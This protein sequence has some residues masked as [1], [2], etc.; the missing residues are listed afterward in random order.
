MTCRICGNPNETTATCC[1]T[2]DTTGKWVSRDTFES[3]MYKV[4][5]NHGVIPP[6]I[7]R[8]FYSDWLNGVSQ[9]AETY[10]RHTSD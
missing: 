4:W 6:S 8:D 1:P 9:D 3:L 7:V 10:L 2:P 5:G